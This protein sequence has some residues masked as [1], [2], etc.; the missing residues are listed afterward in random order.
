[1]QLLKFS[2]K[3]SIE[4]ILEKSRKNSSQFFITKALTV[5]RETPC[6]DSRTYIYESFSLFLSFFLYR[7]GFLFSE[8]I[9]GDHQKPR[10]HRSFLSGYRSLNL[11]E[12]KL[13]AARGTCA[14]LCRGTQ[15]R[16]MAVDIVICHPC[17]FSSHSRA[18]SFR[19]RHI[20]PLSRI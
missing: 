11:S 2:K 19:F 8:A 4:L 17:S 15:A 14:D 6:I 3:I 9:Y 10:G 20:F 7:R 18:I 13:A 5:S 12:E 1:M 16:A